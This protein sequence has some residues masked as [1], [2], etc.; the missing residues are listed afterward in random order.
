MRKTSICVFIKS[1]SFWNQSTINFLLFCLDFIK[2]IVRGN[3]GR[4]KDEECSNAKF[5]SIESS[6]LNSEH[7]HNDSLDTKVEKFPN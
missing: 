6:R 1:F 5:V 7:K 3:E 2:L 4:G